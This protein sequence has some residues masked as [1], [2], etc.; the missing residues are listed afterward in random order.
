MCIRDRLK[1][2]SCIAQNAGFNPLEKLGD[3]MAEQMQ[4]NADYM[5]MDCE[6]GE[7]IDVVQTGI[8]DPAL[9]KLHAVQAAGEVAI[10]ILRINTLIKMREANSANT[11]N[12]E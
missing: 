10:A 7:I 2:F 1:P 11:V 12:L 9:V 5:G 3:V 4:K 6:T 8:L